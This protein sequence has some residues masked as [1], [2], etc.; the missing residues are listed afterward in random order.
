MQ[1][2]IVELQ[3]THNVGTP[4]WATIGDS[5]TLVGVLR[6]RFPDVNSPFVDA[7]GVLEDATDRTRPS[8]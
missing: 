1:S 7:K 4:R 5:V 3:S 8:I 6:R 2:G